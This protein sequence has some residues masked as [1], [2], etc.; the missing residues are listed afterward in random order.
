[1]VAKLMNNK[2]LTK[3][4]FTL[5]Q[6]NMVAKRSVCLYSFSSCFTLAQF[7]MVAKHMQEKLDEAFRF[8]LAQF[9]MVAKRIPKKEA[10]Q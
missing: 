3:L 1:M 2:T 5:A 8:T 6:F 9:N 10:I 4:R 7:N